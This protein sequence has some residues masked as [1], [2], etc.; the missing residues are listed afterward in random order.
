M[1]TTQQLARINAP[2]L[3]TAT[4]RLLYAS[5]PPRV[6]RGSHPVVATRAPRRRTWMMVAMII[7]ITAALVVASLA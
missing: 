1:V 6:A 2:Q 3:V 7:V 4:D 5:R